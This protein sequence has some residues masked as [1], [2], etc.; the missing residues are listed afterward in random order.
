MDQESI[1]ATGD[2][3]DPGL[4]RRAVIGWIVL[5]LL[6]WQFSYTPLWN[7]LLG[8]WALTGGDFDVEL[9]L[10]PVFGFVIGGILGGLAVIGYWRL[11]RDKGVPRAQWALSTIIGY[12]LGQG[13][14]SALNL[15]MLSGLRAAQHQ[16]GEALPPTRW[17]P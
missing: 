2:K 15:W 12:A 14:A 13:A 1:A 16:P 6:A 4:S 9:Y 8:A 3:Q 10:A 11:L 17:L 5:T 7:E